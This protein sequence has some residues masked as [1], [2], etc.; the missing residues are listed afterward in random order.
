M[1]SW[2]KVPTL[3]GA[4]LCNEYSKSISYFAEKHNLVK[5][6]TYSP[7]DHLHSVVVVRTAIIRADTDHISHYTGRTPSP[8]WS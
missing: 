6:N 7:S 2:L 3:D 5:H 1:V 4:L 8:S